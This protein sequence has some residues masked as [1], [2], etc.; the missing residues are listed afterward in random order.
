MPANSEIASRHSWVENPHV[1]PLRRGAAQKVHLTKP[2]RHEHQ[3]GIPI[4]DQTPSAEEDFPSQG[5]R[6]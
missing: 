2:Q 6:H 5:R 3:P 4:V 1:A